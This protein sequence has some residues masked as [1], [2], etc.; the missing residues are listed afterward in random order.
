M[1]VSGG[2]FKVAILAHS[3][4]YV[5][6]YGGLLSVL[7]SLRQHELD[8]S[9]LPNIFLLYFCLVSRGMRPWDE[10]LLYN[11]FGCTKYFAKACLIL[12]ILYFN[13]LIGEK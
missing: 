3:L 4:F 11:R 2:I 10:T 9:V 1:S 13:R 5:W 6:W 7:F 12:C 8:Y